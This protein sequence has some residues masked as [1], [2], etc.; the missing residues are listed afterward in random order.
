MD[1]NDYAYT[2]VLTH[3]VDH[4]SLRAYSFFSKH[5]LCFMKRSLYNNL[6]RA[7]TKDI[8]FRDCL[9]SLKWFFLYPLVRSGLVCDP[10]ERAITD[11]MEIEK[12]YRMTSTFFFMPFPNRPGFVEEGMAAHKARAT[13]YDV[14]KYQWLL[15]KIES[16]GWE[17][18]L[19]GIDAH[20]GVNEAKEELK[21]IQDLLP[22]KKEIGMRMHWLYQSDDLWRNLKEAGFYYD[23]TF[24]TNEGVGFP[25]DKYKPFKKDGIWVIPLNFQ[26]AALLD[27]CGMKLPI[28]DS[29]PY[30]EKILNIARGK[31]AVVTVCWHSNVFGIYKYYGRLY[32]RILQQAKNDGARGVRC[33]D[34]CNEMERSEMKEA[35]SCNE[36]D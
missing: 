21:V 7:I 35:D 6:L 8:T 24:G 31:K 16:E 33:I 25:E 19:H 23:A 15:Q 9:D 17:V 18:G 1:S 14:K 13:V 26:D 30:I 20:L 29:W 32:E 36:N 34:I 3:D 4:L 11:I 22:D 5:S 2:L 12:K 28:T 27:S 10:W